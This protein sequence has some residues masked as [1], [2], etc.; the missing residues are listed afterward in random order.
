MTDKE[1][2]RAEIERLLYEQAPSHDQQCDYEDGYICA[3]CKIDNFI[4]TLEIKKVELE[5]E[6]PIS[7][8]F[9]EEG[10]LTFEDGSQAIIKRID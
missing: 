10:L 9:T 8:T 6:L 7:N 5:E 2:I 3:L 1:I 4:D